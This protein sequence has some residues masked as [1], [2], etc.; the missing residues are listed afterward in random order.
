MATSPDDLEPVLRDE[1][2]AAAAWARQAEQ[3]LAKGKHGPALLAEARA[4]GEGVAAERLLAWSKEHGKPEQNATDEAL[5]AVAKMR[6]FDD[7]ATEKM[8]ARLIDGLL[9]GGDVGRLLGAASDV[10][11]EAGVRNAALDLVRAAIAVSTEAHLEERVELGASLF[12]ALVELGRFDDARAAVDDLHALDAKRAASLRTMLAALTHPFD[13]RAA[14]YLE[15]EPDDDAVTAPLSL[16]DAQ[17][18]LRSIVR[19]AAIVR[20]GIV[21]LVGE[22]AWL[23]T[24]APLLERGGGDARLLPDDAFDVTALGESLPELVFALRKEWARLS[25]AIAALGGT[26]LAMPTAIVRPRCAM[27]FVDTFTAARYDLLCDVVEGK[28]PEARDELEKRLLAS[29]FAGTPLVALEP[30]VAQVWLEETEAAL[31]GLRWAMGRV[32]TPWSA[33]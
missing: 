31:A 12:A 11:H 15:S 22:A 2:R 14:Q 26:S 32:A 8:I 3:L 5:A 33:E 20:A 24:V 13:F 1:A 4:V 27:D 16:A 28:A 21:E 6:R 10:L 29:T 25:W 19:R 30:A 23:P 17:A 7:V 9:R 18:G